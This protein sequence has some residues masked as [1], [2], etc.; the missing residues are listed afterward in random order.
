MMKN[1]SY[2]K[3]A[4]LLFHQ[5]LLSIQSFYYPLNCYLENLPAWILIIF[6][7]SVLKAFWDTAYPSFKQVSKISEINL[8]REKVKTMNNLVK[9]EYLVIW[10]T[11]K[12]NDIVIL[13][14]GD[15]ISKLSKILNDTSK[16]KRVN[17]YEGK[18]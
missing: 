8:S 1:Q 18:A 12:G 2:V 9:N 14:R 17:I 10:K 5:K 13:N 6:I 16:F 3:D 11:G 4:I 15:Y 7:A